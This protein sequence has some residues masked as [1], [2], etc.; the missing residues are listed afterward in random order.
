[1]GKIQGPPDGPPDAG[2][3]SEKCETVEKNSNR[4]KNRFVFGM[5]PKPLL[6]GTLFIEAACIGISV[7]F[8]L[9]KA[10]P[11][12][13]QLVVSIIYGYFLSLMFVAGAGLAAVP[14]ICLLLPLHWCFKCLLD[15]Y[16][17]TPDPK[18]AP[19][20]FYDLVEGEEELPS[21]LE[22]TK[23]KENIV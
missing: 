15:S 23:G 9:G 14:V 19:P 20:S 3:D 6:F 11:G 12:V 13:P 21:F 10:M 8:N 16:R 22:A 7:Y 18:A 4:K 1:M 2:T 17:S 5:I